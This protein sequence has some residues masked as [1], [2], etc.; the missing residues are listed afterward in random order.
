MFRGLR[1]H[2][3]RRLLSDAI[4][5]WFAH[6]RQFSIH[7]QSYYRRIILDFSANIPDRPIDKLKTSDF[8]LYLN[9][10]L[11]TGKKKSSLNNT[12]VA[13]RS[14]GRFLEETYEL[15]NPCQSIKK[16]KAE[17]KVRHFLTYKEYQRILKV[18]SPRQRD[19]VVFLANT[20]L[21]AQEAIDLTWDNFDLSLR[22]L[23]FIGKGG[24]VR[25][26]PLNESVR[27]LL[28]KYLRKSETL[29]FMSKN[30][31]GLYRTLRLVGDKAGIHLTPHLLR[32]YFATELLRRGVPIAF[33]SKCLGH[34]SIAVTEKVYIH[35]LPDYLLGVTDVLD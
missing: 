32:H 11:L 34:S 14:F 30:R 28:L 17:E 20:G 19:I 13:L 9:S 7:T 2:R 3:A 6:I 16:F 33:V 22:R 25:V 1:I 21:R 24:K 35:F 10:L 18:C 4:D 26:V 12:V 8:R 5:E 31:K 15:P 23:T 27:S 29:I